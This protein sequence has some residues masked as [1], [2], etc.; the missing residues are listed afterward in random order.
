MR[1]FPKK[2]CFARLYLHNVILCKMATLF[3]DIGSNSIKSL[4]A[5]F[6]GGKVLA[7]AE[8]AENRRISSAEG[9]KPGAAGIICG[10]VGSLASFA[11]SKCE[12]F[13][14]FCFG[15]SAL[16][17][18]P[19]AKEVLKDLEGRGVKVRA[20]SGE[21]EARL[22]F[23]GA[24]LDPFLKI[25]PADSLVYADLGGGSMEFVVKQGGKISNIKSLPLGAVRLTNAFMKNG[26]LDRAGLCARCKELLSQIPAPEKPFKLVV[27]GGAV[28]AARFIL[29]G[30]KMSERR[31][32]GAADFLGVLNTAETLGAEGLEKKFGTPKNRADIL[33]AAFL[34][35]IEAIKHFGAEYLVHTQYSLRYGVA[36]SY[37]SG[38]ISY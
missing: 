30:G 2:S 33:P 32:L 22:S 36:S 25:S 20:L 24:M 18:S 11:K 19:A 28:S 16:R 27:A 31:R 38:R 37:F 10:A 5:K 14:I 15:T 7:I 21:E 13:D 8:C 12:K 4:L 3:I 1:Q 23:E 34:C 26:P 29:G 17:D 35:L 6:E 9:L